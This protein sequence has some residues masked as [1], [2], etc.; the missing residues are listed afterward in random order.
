MAD[1]M[2]QKNGQPRNE[3]QVLEI[4]QLRDKGYSWRML[5]DRFGMSRQGPKLLYEKWKP[6]AEKRR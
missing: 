1:I 2:R 3:K 6:W 4:I 5:G